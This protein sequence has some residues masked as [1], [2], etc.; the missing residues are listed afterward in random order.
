VGLGAGWNE[1]EHV[2][3]GFEYPSTAERFDMLEDQLAILHG[4]WT[5]PDGWSYQG[6]HWSIDDALFYPK[7]AAPAGR[8]HPNVIVGGGGRPR[9]AALVARYADEINVSSMA[10]AEAAEAYARVAAACRAIGRNPD[11]VTRSAMTGILLGG[12]DAEV[13]RRVADVLA[14]VGGAGDP[15]AW[16]AARRA[17]WIMGTPDEARARVEEF[18]AAGVQRLMLQTFLPRDLDMVGLAARVL[19]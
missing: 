19:L 1:L 2:Q 16:L 6:K 13:S 17:R 3:H 9:M 10:P 18:A 5:Q 7:P 15:D 11:E 8:R 4:L 14:V 12:D